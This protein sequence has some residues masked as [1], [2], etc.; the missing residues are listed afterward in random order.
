[1]KAVAFLYKFT[2]LQ[3]L[4]LAG[5]VAAATPAEQEIEAEAQKLFPKIF[6]KCGEDYF[7]KRT[8]SSTFAILRGTCL[9][10]TCTGAVA[11]PTRRRGPAHT[12]WFP[13]APARVLRTPGD[14]PVC[15][16]TTAPIR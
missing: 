14:Q 15:E 13:G 8:F 2:L 7:S 11:A 9:T 4:L 5:M 10:L 16:N 6:S 1:M 12:G 3:L